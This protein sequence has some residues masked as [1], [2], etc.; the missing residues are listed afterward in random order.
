[1]NFSKHI[2]KWLLGI[3]KAKKNIGKHTKLS[4]PQ[5]ILRPALGKAKA[6]WFKL[7]TMAE[8]SLSYSQYK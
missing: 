3:K 2:L 6:S 5:K 1:M 4:R 7:T 8:I